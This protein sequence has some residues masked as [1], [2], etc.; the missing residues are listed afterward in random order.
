[1]FLLL[2][3]TVSDEMAFYYAEV[4]PTGTGAVNT[5]IIYTILH[6][7]LSRQIFPPTAGYWMA[8]RRRLLYL[9]KFKR[10]FDRMAIFSYNNK[11]SLFFV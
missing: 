8:Q 10:F 4:A 5:G 11:N 2:D 7:Q 1:M 3:F 9:N 6:L